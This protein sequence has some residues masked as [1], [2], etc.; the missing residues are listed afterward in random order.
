[1]VKELTFED[2][3]R[4]KL[5]SGAHK[6]AQAVRTTLG[7]RGRSAVPACAHSSNER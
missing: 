5:L 3:A 1:M 4:K 7:P 6:L 2:E